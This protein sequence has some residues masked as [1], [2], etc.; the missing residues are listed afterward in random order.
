MLTLPPFRLIWQ[1]ALML[2]FGVIGGTLATV[3]HLP[4]PWMLGGLFSSAA[5]VL[6]WDPWI[7]RDYDFPMRFR[8]GFVALIGVMIGTQVTPELAAMAGQFTWTMAGLVV[9]VLCAHLGNMLIF[10]RLGG[11]DR[12]TA[13]YSGTPGGLTESIVM[14]EGAGADIRILTAQQFLRIIVVITLLP[15][16]L[17]LWLGAPVGSAAGLSASAPEEPVTPL[18]LMLICLAAAAG[19]GL[20]KLVNLPAGQLSGPLLLVAGFTVTGVV[21][22]HLPVWLIASAQLVIG[23]SLGMRFKGANMALLR[24]CLWLAV[25]S[26]AYMMALGGALSWVLYQITGI[27]WLHLLISFA[28]GGVAEM[29]IVALSLAANPALVSLH[30][31]ARIL[32]TVVEMGVVSRLLKLR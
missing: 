2:A 14:G 21:E 28:P 17:S 15:L 12:A 16:G 9:F 19:L 31:V 7:L 30:H 27:E 6:I 24:R 22:L 1:S 18:A 23:V 11:Y 10:Q 3:L 4:M 20:A 5:V 32:M 13:F 26:V 25:V 29:S 8:T